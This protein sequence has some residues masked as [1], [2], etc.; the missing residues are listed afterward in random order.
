[1]WSSLTLQLGMVVLDVD[2][3]DRSIAFYR[4]LGLDVPDPFPGRPVALH[5]MD[6]GV[7]IVLVRGFAA[8]LDPDWVRPESYQQALEF[9]VGSDAEV[10]EMWTRLTSAGYH[11]RLAPTTR[12]GPYAALV[13]DPDGNAVLISSDPA[14]NPAANA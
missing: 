3:V 12:T 2:D 14:A 6:S 4:L 10:D 1:M 5:T 9:S 13:D 7:S 11:G 8:G